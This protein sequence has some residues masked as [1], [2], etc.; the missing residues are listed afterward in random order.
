[1]ITALFVF[2]VSTF[3]AW[4]L[5]S[6]Y[7][8]QLRHSKATWLGV[9]F[10][11]LFFCGLYYAYTLVNRSDS[12]AYY[13]KILEQHRGDSW[14]DFYKVGTPFIEFVG[15]PF[16]Q[17]LG[18]SYEAMMLLFA[19]FGFVGL[20]YFY[21]TALNLLQYR[22]K[23]FGFDVLLLMLFLPNIHFWSVSLGKGSLMFMGLGL[24]FY[25]LSNIG[26]NW[27]SLALGT[28]LV[29]HIRAHI[30]LVIII[31]LLAAVLFSSK[32]IRAWQ[33]ILIVVVGLAALAPVANTFLAYAGLEEADSTEIV[34]FVDHRSNELAKA[35]SSVD[36]SNYN[37]VFKL[38]TFLFRPLFI[39]APN[40]LGLVVSFEN[41]FYLFFLFR[42]LS[43]NFI[44]FLTS[45]PW[46]IKV[47]LITF[48]GVSF[49]LAQISGN[50]GIAI[51]QK[52]QV[53]FLFFLVVLAY[54]DWMY[55]TQGKKILGA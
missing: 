1:M 19:F 55:R 13:S 47:A 50:M 28:V 26:R 48:L 33:K 51:R 12:K 15:Y 24:L 43:F 41:M 5:I 37:Q 7:Q 35:G 6:A 3:L 45:S 52:S 22:H 25:G 9:F 10:Y 42:I 8:S 30:M 23:L 49:A 36:L 17:Y 44:R 2:F 16:V 32:G 20:F 27:L 46:I 53:M 40:A 4:W 11:H 18:F 39:D 31:A 34:D 38:F 29:F 54:A 21:L 14:I